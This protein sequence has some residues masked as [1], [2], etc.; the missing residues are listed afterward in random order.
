MNPP[1][2]DTERLIL[3]APEAGDFPTYRDFYADAD[4]SAF[5]GGPLPAHRAW[6]VLA[7]D[8]G[9]WRLRGYG[10][11]SVCERATG[12]MIGGCGLVWPE[13]WPRSELTW[14]I[15][16]AARRRGY[17]LEASRAV[18]AFGYEILRWESV[19]THIDD[20]NSAARDLT[21]KLGAEHIAR[22]LFPDGL[23]RN[24]YRFPRPQ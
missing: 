16:P 19:E 24:V 12:I 18:I 17:A 7:G 20:A 15:I 11:W 14:W 4:A 8:L 22:D 9:H 5:Y 10:M 1:K 2:L 23:E 6:R 13:G 21:L 3:R